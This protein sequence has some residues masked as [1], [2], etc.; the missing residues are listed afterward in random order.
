MESTPRRSGRRLPLAGRILIAM[1]LGVATGVGLGKDAVPLGQIGTVIIELIKALAAP[2][3]LFAVLDAFLRTRVKARD[4]AV[5]VGISLGNALLAVLIG[6]ALSNAL[7]P[8]EHLRQLANAADQAKVAQF[9]GVQRIDFLKEL[10]G[11]LPTNVVKPFVDN[12]I[13]TI[14]ILAVLG[15]SALRRVKE[16]QEARGERGYRAVEDF[17]STCYRA[18]EVALG[19]LIRLVPLA[20]FAAVARSVGENSLTVLLRGLAVYVGV[21]VLGLAIQVFVIY[22]GWLVLVARMPLRRFWAG[23]RDPVAYALGASSSLAT[24]PVTLRGLDRMGVSPQSSRLAACVGTNLNNDGILLYEAMAALFVAQVYGIALTLPQQALI[25][26]SCVVAG[27][28]IGGIPDAGL[29]SLAVVLATARLPVDILPVLLTV[30]WMLSRC[31]AMTNVTSDMLVA[32]LLDRFGAGGKPAPPDD[33][34][35]AGHGPGDRE[36][37]GRLETARISDPDGI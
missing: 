34:T 31:R 11:Y 9:R 23:A 20:V 16:E 26:A 32:V 14:V 35:A 22:Q 18:A 17:V 12:V 15:G 19:W 13:I 10:T 7:R 27:I 36:P 4:G 37:E 28:G 29:I 25:A 33:F 5:M 1:L 30:D 24:L 21:A 3:L 8:G 6:L 2:L